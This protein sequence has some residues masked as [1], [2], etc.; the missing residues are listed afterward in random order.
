MP[1]YWLTPVLGRSPLRLGA[2]RILGQP[3]GEFEAFRQMMHGLHP[4][5]L[6]LFKADLLLSDDEELC[7]SNMDVQLDLSEAGELIFN[8]EPLHL[9]HCGEA[10]LDR[11]LRNEEAAALLL[12]DK[13][14]LWTDAQLGWKHICIEWLQ[15]GWSIIILR[16][17]GVQT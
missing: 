12:L 2:E 16:E 17:D 7:G 5:L 10:F 13:G 3:L 1:R 8:G 6:P 11:L 4:R 14:D 15:R 9:S